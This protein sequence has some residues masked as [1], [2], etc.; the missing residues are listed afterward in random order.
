MKQNMTEAEQSALIRDTVYDLIVY[1]KYSRHLPKENRRETWEE[2]VDRTFEVYEE[3]LRPILT[4]E[5]WAEFMDVKAA[6]NKRLILGSMRGYQFGGEAFRQNNARGYNCWGMIIDSLDSLGN[7][8]WL[9]LSGGGVGFNLHPEYLAKL[10][11]LN[12]AYHDDGLLGSIF[13]IPDTIEGWADSVKLLLNSYHNGGASVTMDYSLIRPEGSP[14][15]TSGGKAP[16]H[17]GLKATHEKIREVLEYAISQGKERLSS[18]DVLDLACHI[19]DAVLSGGV[20]RSALLA[21][22]PLVDEAMMLAKTEYQVELD[23]ISCCPNPDIALVSFTWKGKKKT[24]GVDI[25][26]IKDGSVKFSWFELEPQRAR[27]NI[28]VCL[29]RDKCSLEDFQ[30]VLNATKQW[31]EPGFIFADSLLT[32]VNPCAEIGFIPI[33]SDGRTGAQACNLITINGS[34]AKTRVGFYKLC[35][36]AAILGTV[37]ASFTDFPYLKDA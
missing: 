35:E 17:E 6:V 7:L 18:V 19:S 2:I 28:S 31:G 10:P 34:Q 14:L 5:D 13:V 1:T 37:Q 21:S 29:E 3:K 27:V 15:R 23:T 22:F 30:R 33:T 16:G 36:W 11:K 4:T 26:R 25:K 12:T 9:L 32:T 8:A 24:L 20:R